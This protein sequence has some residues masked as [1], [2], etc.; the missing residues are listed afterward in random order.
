MKAEEIIWGGNNKC[1]F[2]LAHDINLPEGVLVEVKYDYVQ[3][4]YSLY[5]GGDSTL[6]ELNDVNKRLL[7]NIYLSQTETLKLMLLIPMQS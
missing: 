3:E 2:K 1:E 7:D 6:I 4:K 5:Y